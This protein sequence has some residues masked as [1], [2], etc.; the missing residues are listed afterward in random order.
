MTATST[1]KTKDTEIVINREFA[2]P[3]Q[4]VWEVWT[5]PK[6]IE[7][8]FGPKGFSTRVE[9]FD[10][11]VGGRSTYVMV[12]PDGKEYPG[13][14]VYREIVPIEKIVTTDEFG[15]GFEESH[16]EMD[17][18]QGMVTTFL[19]DDAGTSLLDDSQKKT[20]LTL[21]IAHPTAEDRKKH[22]AMGVVDGWSSSFDKLN[23]YLAE[24]QK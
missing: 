4:L 2:A 17:L 14:G 7:K 15:E 13:T 11:K 5:Q 10:F 21:I 16:P 20:K 22:E 1:T 18:P 24:V 23:E 19:F 8:W 6:H 12:G 3:R 9:K